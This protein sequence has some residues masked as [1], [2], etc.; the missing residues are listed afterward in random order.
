MIGGVTSSQLYLFTRQFASMMGS[1]LQL[2]TVLSNLARETPNRRLRQVLEE[3]TDDL[4]AGVDLADSLEKHPRIFNSI[5][6]NVIRSGLNASQLPDALQHMSLYLEKV[7]DLS[8]KIKSSVMYPVFI[9]IVFCL[10]FNVMSFLVLPRFA[11]L[12]GSLGRELPVP[13]QIMMRLANGYIDNWHLIIGGLAAVVALFVVWIS[14]EAGRAVWDD[15][16][17]RLPV[18]GSVWRTAAISR[19]LRTFAVQLQNHIPAVQAIRIAAKAT[20]NVYITEI[21]WDIAQRVEAGETMA[22]AFRREEIFGGVVQQIVT[23]GEEAGMLDNLMLSAA[24]YF[25]TV[26]SQRISGLTALIN[27][28]LTA[29]VGCGIAGML[30]AAFLPVFEMSGSVR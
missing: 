11:V 8:K 4:Y 13:T 10:V 5:Y 17:L 28:L 16:K 20:S 18:V 21:I 22:S 6:V 7:D 14:S 30:I 12:F 23:S 1:R 2:V 3:V 27:P 9:L 29:V 19:F 26:I 24:S 15:L 25:D